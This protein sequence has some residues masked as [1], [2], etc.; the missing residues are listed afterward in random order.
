MQP[1]KHF[2]CDRFG[3]DGI[4]SFYDLFEYMVWI[5]FINVHAKVSVLLL[6]KNFSFFIIWFRF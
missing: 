1:G 4:Y 6:H 2:G 5:S 3:Y